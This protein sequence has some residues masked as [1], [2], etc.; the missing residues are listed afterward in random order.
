[1][2]TKRFLI[3]FLI[4]IFSFGNIAQALQV[5]LSNTF[6]Q[7]IY[8]LPADHDGHYRKVKLITPDKPVSIS[9]IDSNGSQILFMNL[10]NATY[11]FQMG[12]IKKGEIV[13]ITGE[14]EVSIEH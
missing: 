12:P 14:G 6:K 3:I 11:T 1:M 7:G 9:I 4:C 5:P 10:S 2:K 8:P 13:I